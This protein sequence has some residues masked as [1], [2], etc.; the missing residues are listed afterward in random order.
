MTYPILRSG[1]SKIFNLSYY[2]ISVLAASDTCGQ[3]TFT[4]KI[5]GSDGG[6]FEDP[7]D[8]L[9]VKCVDCARVLL[10]NQL[11]FLRINVMCVTYS[12]D[13]F[14][15]NM[16]NRVVYSAPVASTRACCVVPFATHAKRASFKRHQALVSAIHVPKA[17]TSSI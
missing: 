6:F 11:L 15:H 2:A 9:A 10:A 12:R 3:G 17:S 5:T 16:G 1:F 13:C 7:L 8:S 14:K 4:T